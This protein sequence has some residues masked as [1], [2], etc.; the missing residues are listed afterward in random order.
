MEDCSVM[1]EDCGVKRR[2][3]VAGCVCSRLCIKPTLYKSHARF[4]CND[5]RTSCC[6][7]AAI[8]SL[9]LTLFT[10]RVKI[11][12]ESM[13]AFT[14]YWPRC[15]FPHKLH[16]PVFVCLSAGLFYRG[17]LYRPQQR[18]SI[19]RK[20]AAISI[21]LNKQQIFVFWIWISSNTL[22]PVQHW[23]HSEQPASK[24]EIDG[25]SRLQPSALIPAEW[26]SEDLG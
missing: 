15:H 10:V 18:N 22:I 17:R 8:L 14:W 19:C 6:L 7:W 12:W 20:Q 9:I 21:E 23:G 4:L 16:W 1:R 5:L 26:R 13:G 24:K 2:I 3:K 25:H 11:L